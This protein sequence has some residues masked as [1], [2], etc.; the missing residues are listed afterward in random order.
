MN[1]LSTLFSAALLLGA[2]PLHAQWITE[3]YALK[4][5]W[6]AI[7]LHGAASGTPDQIFSSGDGL[8]VTEIWRWN[9]NPTQVQYTTTPL[10][11][12]PGTPEWSVWK[13]GFPL[14]SNLSTMSGQTAYLVK[15]DGPASG[16]FSI[17]LKLSPLVPGTAWL[18][19]GAN[20]LGFPSFGAGNSSPLF[21]SYFAT[22]PAAIAPSTK[23]YKYVGGEFGQLNPMQVL[24]P[25]T[26]RLDR[27]TAYWFDSEVVSN[28]YAP[29]EF[30]LSN[31][32]G[33]DFGRTGSGVTVRV[34]N[35][36]GAP[37]TLNFAPVT[38]E[39]APAGE[40]TVAGAVPLTRRSFN[41]ITAAWTEVALPGSS[42]E[43]I[44]PQSTVELNFGINRGL[45]STTADT[46]YASMLRFTDSGNLVDL[47]LPVR[48]KS[49]SLAGLWMGDAV[50]TAV[51][52]RAK[53]TAT[54]TATINQTGAVIGLTLNTRGLGYAGGDAGVTIEPPSGGGGAATA[55]ALVSQ[56]TVTGFTLTHGGQGYSE[57]PAVTITAPSAP[58][59]GVG[60]ARPA[61]LRVLWHID[62][63]GRARLLS[64]VYMGKL[65]ST[66]QVGLCT[67]ESLLKQDEK[68]SAARLSAVHLPMELTL[69]E[70]SATPALL[71]STLSYAVRVDYQDP[72]NPFVHIYHPDHDNLNA[73][74]TDLLPD[75]VESH[76]IDR[77]M[78]FELTP[79]PPAGSSSAGWGSTTI[80]G[81]YHEI[82]KGLSRDDLEVS[83]TFELRR[84]SEFSELT[85]N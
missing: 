14:D 61:P 76:T 32:N 40:A 23:I 73:R 8:K 33:L 22:F 20:L 26:E 31:P 50:V 19:S 12:S 37:V 70:S 67:K 46:F 21:S 7:Q 51:Q 24:S 77:A 9:P 35:R 11:P 16:T 49:S 75:G 27:H 47:T 34:S 58:P 29:L 36:G 3:T 17:P 10:I 57:A 43:V 1:K 66:G 42:S 54:A 82:I 44:A 13:R 25:S 60:T 63:S 83:G 85:T 18:R 45:M 53:F 2:A 72:T 15:C 56:G 28:F 71:G 59:G 80:G 84:V 79:A 48:A 52:N 68:A 69:P 30:S 81:N 4:G 74:R 65:A 5:G 62:A 78:S 39:T 41:A 6:N 38:S 55:L 64:V